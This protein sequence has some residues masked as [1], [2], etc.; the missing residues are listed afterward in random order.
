[1]PISSVRPCNQ[2]MV[3]SAAAVAVEQPLA[4]PA[5]AGSSFVA[6]ALVV[7]H[8]RPDSL[9]AAAVA[10]WAPPLDCTEVAVG[11]RHKPLL[12]AA[13]V[14]DC[15]GWAMGTCAA[16]GWR[17]FV[18]SASGR[19]AFDSDRQRRTRTVVVSVAAVAVV[20]VREAFAA[21]AAVDS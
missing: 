9:A 14:V 6:A 4:V 21:A 10:C 7:D 13:V 3:E 18:A 5:S 20:V 11:R 1:M 12:A 16:A 17:T 15:T 2:D 8:R 19:L